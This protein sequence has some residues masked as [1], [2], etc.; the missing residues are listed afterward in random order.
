MKFYSVETKNGKVSFSSDLSHE[1]ACEILKKHPEASDPSSFPARLIILFKGDS[2]MSEKQLTWMI[3]MAQEIVDEE[4]MASSI[5]VA[6]TSSAVVAAG[7]LATLHKPFQVAGLKRFS[8]RF[9][10]VR[11]AQAPSSGRNTGHLY[12]YENNQ[13]LGKIT[14]AGRYIGNSSSSALAKLEEAA[15]NPYE[16][17]IRHGRQTNTCSCC[18]ATL[19]DPVSVQIGIGPVC[20]ERIAGKG[21]R[22]EVKE[23][24]KKGE[25]DTFVKVLFHM[26]Q[27]DAKNEARENRGPAQIPDRSSYRDESSYMI[28]RSLQNL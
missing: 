24:I 18:G 27:I 2:Y 13:Y 6:K 8:M 3:K 21:A 22:K 15:L 20:L 19:T 4:K 14:P 5:V 25:V 23:A 10:A 12:V 26:Q 7:S 16:A 17:A 11:V 28:A 9:G 1:Q